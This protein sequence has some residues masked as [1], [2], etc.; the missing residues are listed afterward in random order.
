MSPTSPASRRGR[1]HTLLMVLAHT[2]SDF[3][4]TAFTPL[5]ATFQSLLGLTLTGVSAIGALVGIFGSMMQ[6]LM[7]L[8]SDRAHRGAMAAAGVLASAVFFGLIGFSPN[9]VVLTLLLVAGSLGVAAFHP[10]GAVLVVRD[11]ARRHAAMGLYMTGGGLGLALAPWVTT[12][13][14]GHLGLAW[15]WLIALPGIGLAVWLYA[16]T[17]HEPPARASG[18]VLNW[19]ALFAPGTGAGWALFGVAFLRSVGVTAFTYFAS[20]LG[21]ARGWRLEE[22]GDVLSWFL[23]LGMAGSLLGGH[24]AGRMDRRVLIAASCVLAAPC[25]L[26][27]AATRGGLSVPAF[28]VAGFLFSLATPVNVSLAQELYPRSA[29]PMSGVIMGMA[30]GLA[31]LLLIGVGR[32]AERFGVERALQVAAVFGALAAVFVVFLP[33]RGVRAGPGSPR[34][35]LR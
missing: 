22:T 8:W 12:R 5:V 19:R 30:W 3:Y 24:L 1:P 4:A 11:E 18:R 14:V 32:A 20:V 6:P 23:G 21:R 9:V 10:A 28:A 29:G 27:F 33:G 17:R 34:S 31:S 25:F 13:I 26:A 16:A 35:A 2:M 7:G 15:L